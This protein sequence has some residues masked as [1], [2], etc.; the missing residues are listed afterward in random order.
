MRHLT[1]SVAAICAAFLLAGCSTPRPED[2]QGTG[3]P[4]P[5]DSVAG[6]GVPGAATSSN[7]LDTLRVLPIRDWAQPSR[8][9]LD[10]AQTI[11][12][13]FYPR[14]SRDRLSLRE[15]FW[16]HR[17]VRSYR[18]AME[19]AMEAAAPLEQGS[20]AGTSTMRVGTLPSDRVIIEPQ[21]SFL[22]GM[23]A[24]NDRLPWAAPQPAATIPIAPAM[25]GGNP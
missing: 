11:T 5:V 19:R 6:G 13:W 2:A 8:P 14:I 1:L 7:Q 4:G 9:I 10:G 3:N 15:G 24:L 22:R 16:M 20:A 23:S 12:I 17:M 21:Q 18:W 25:P